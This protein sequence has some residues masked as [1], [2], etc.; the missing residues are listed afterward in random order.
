MNNYYTKILKT[1]K[2]PRTASFL[3]YKGQFYR[4]LPDECR[5]NKNIYTFI[6]QDG[7]DRGYHELWIDVHAAEMFLFQ[8]NYNTDYESY[9]TTELEHVEKLKSLNTGKEVLNRIDWKSTTHF[10]TGDYV[11]G[12]ISREAEW[13]EE[14]NRFSI[15]DFVPEPLFEY[16]EEEDDEEMIGWKISIKCFNCKHF[17]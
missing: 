14:K 10:I 8:D 15:K 9:S 16:K 4:H 11:I 12:P 2:D 17:H 1:N 13:V 3:L 6:K 5:K 7:A